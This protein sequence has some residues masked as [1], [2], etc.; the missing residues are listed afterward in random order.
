MHQEVVAQRVPRHQ[1]PNHLVTVDDLWK[2][3]SFL[4]FRNNDVERHVLGWCRPN[5]LNDEEVLA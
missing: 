3:A 1:S 2:L 5:V 4:P